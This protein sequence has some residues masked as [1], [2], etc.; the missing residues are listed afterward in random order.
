MVQPLETQWK[1]NLESFDISIWPEVVSC[2][3]MDG[4]LI[5]VRLFVVLV[6][7]EIFFFVAL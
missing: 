5:V 7:K 4:S 2:S 6:A 1:L 3:G